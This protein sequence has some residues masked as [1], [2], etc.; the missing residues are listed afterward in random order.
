MQTNQQEYDSLM[1]IRVKKAELRQEIDKSGKEVAKLWNGIFHTKNTNPLSPTQKL[2]SF[3]STSSG[4]I[5]GALLGWK[6]Y[7]KLRK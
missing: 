2:L 1:A 4:I 6:L 7:R 3:A 5:D